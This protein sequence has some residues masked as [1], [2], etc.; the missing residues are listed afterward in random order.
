[1]SIIG[2]V[3]RAN[4]SGTIAWRE[5]ERR[6]EARLPLGSLDGKQLRRSFFGRHPDDTG[7][8]ETDQGYRLALAKMEAAQRDLDVGLILAG[9]RLTV[10]RYLRDWIVVCEDRVE[11]TTWRRY[12]QIVEN[13]LIPRIGHVQLVKLTAPAVERIL[14]DAGKAGLSPQTVHHMRSV[15]RTALTRAEKHGLVRNNVAKL[16]ESPKVEKRERPILTP[17]EVRR[18]LILVSGSRYEAL[19]WLAVLTGLRKGELLR[20]RADDVDLDAKTLLVR[21]PKNKKPRRIGLPDPLIPVLR[22]HL[23]A[24][25]MERRVAMDD[26]WNAG[27]LLFTLPNG[28]PVYNTAVHRDWEKARDALQRP[29]M[30]WHDLRHSANTL[31]A[32]LGISTRDRMT[33]LGHSSSKMTED[34]YG[35]SLPEGLRDAADRVSAWLKE[36][37]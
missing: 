4:G 19:Y 9:P 16:A 25:E 32:S 14:H 11:P 29:E 27:G 36:A 6:W 22:R 30:H 8:P 15:L 10:A 5:K 28:R 2:D 1:M 33:I 13:N 34:I 3:R 17:D 20:L 31:M 12:R 18:L 24:Q 7:D 37:K 26:A 23:A 35:H 21:K